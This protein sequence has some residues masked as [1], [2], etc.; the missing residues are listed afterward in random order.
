MAVLRKVGDFELNQGHGPAKRLYNVTDQANDTS[1]LATLKM[2]V[3]GWFDSEEKNRL[4]QL[5]DIE[6]EKAC[7]LKIAQSLWSE[8]G[9]IP[10]N[11]N[12][13]ID[14]NFDLSVAEDLMYQ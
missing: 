6:F 2:V 11:E 13:E 4:M 7:K 5:S 10:V 1:V 12:E 14:E 8:L 9:Y 3:T